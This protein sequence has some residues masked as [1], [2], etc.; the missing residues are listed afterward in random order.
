[1][2][3]V[4]QFAAVVI[5]V[6]AAGWAVVLLSTYERPPKFRVEDAFLHEGWAISRETTPTTS[7]PGYRLVSG[8]SSVMR[9]VLLDSGHPTVVDDETCGELWVELPGPKAIGQATTYEQPRA[10]LILCSCVF[11]PCRD[12]GL[13]AISVQV[14]RSPNGTT[15]AKVGFA[16]DTWASTHDVQLQI[17]PAPEFATTGR[18]LESQSNST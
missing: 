9:L 1:M 5:V 15:H 8:D 6:L 14:L 3:V 4:I 13:R 16:G 12:T 11:G 10:A 18:L 7:D 17:M 2:R